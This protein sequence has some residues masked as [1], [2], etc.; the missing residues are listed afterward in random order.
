MGSQAPLSAQEVEPA[1]IERGDGSE[2]ADQ[3]GILGKSGE[4]SQILTQSHQFRGPAVDHEDAVLNT[5]AVRLKL[6]RDFIAPAVVGDVVGD[7][8][9][10]RLLGAHRVRIPR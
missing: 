7:E 3:D 10:A 6:L 8:I 9:P 1:A 2:V 5:V 4:P